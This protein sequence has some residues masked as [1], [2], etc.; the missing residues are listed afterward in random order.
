MLL[1]LIPEAGRLVWDWYTEKVLNIE[2]NHR[3]HTIVTGA[4]MIVFGL[5]DWWLGPTKYFFQPIVFEFTLFVLTFD[6]LRNWIVGKK[7]LYVDEGLDGHTSDNDSFMLGIKW[8][9]AL[10]M[11]LIVMLF[12]FSIYFLWSWVESYHY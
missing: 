2:V 5:L 11:R 6:Y 4:A 1:L 8:W 3:R 9:A 7:I 12:G 10:T